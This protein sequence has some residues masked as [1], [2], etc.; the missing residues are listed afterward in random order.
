MR[1]RLPVGRTL[2]FLG[3]FALSMIALIPMRMAVD[4][5][6]MADRGF[7]ARYVT[8][9]IW[10]GGFREAQF[11]NVGLGDVDAGLHALPLLAG[12][13]RI[14]LSRHEGAAGDA[15]S[16]A[17]L[18]TRNTFGFDDVDGRLVMAAGTFGRLP[19]SHIDLTDV[20][21]RFEGGQCAE[22]AGTVRLMLSGDLG[23]VS[24]PAGLSGTV[25]CDAGAL[26][27]ATASQSGMEAV[28]VRIDGGGQYSANMLVRTT[29]TNLRD[30]MV[31][32]G[33]APSAQGYGMTV[34]GRF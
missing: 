16:G 5:S 29:D 18:I 3:S 30:R 17:A 33:L 19:L 25:R 10:A 13:A 11:A 24:L 15:F 7:A 21:V 34:S 27:V 20:T 1:I 28:D 4:G 32:S 22:A 23:G 9:T 12:R 31:A 14:A 8:G 6:G 26:L 2:F